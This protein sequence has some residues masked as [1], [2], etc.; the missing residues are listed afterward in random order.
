[1]KPFYE[2]IVQSLARIDRKRRWFGVAVDLNRF[3]AGIHDDSAVLA[4]AEVLLD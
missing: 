3:L 1:M 2:G 4:L